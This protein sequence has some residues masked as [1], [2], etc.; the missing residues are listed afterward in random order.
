MTTKNT[1]G[2]K[3]VISFVAFILCMVIGSFVVSL[4]Y[5]DLSY[6]VVFIIFCIKYY[7]LEG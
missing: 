1:Y 2:F 6:I 7:R 3:V 5:I 4:K